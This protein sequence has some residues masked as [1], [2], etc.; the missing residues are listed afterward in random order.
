MTKVDRQ[1]ASSETLVTPDWVGL[2]VLA[3]EGDRP[4]YCRTCGLD[5]ERDGT[6][7]RCEK[8]AS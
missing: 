3:D 1:I 6:C 2:S 8:A 4:D 7:W 5:F